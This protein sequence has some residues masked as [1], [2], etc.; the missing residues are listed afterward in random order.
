MLASR[1]AY[2]TALTTE[3]KSR[4]I[5]KHKKFN[6]SSLGIKLSKF[7]GYNSNLDIYTFQDKFEKLALK[8]TPID[9]LP[10]LLK[11]TYLEDPALSLVKNVTDIDDIWKRLKDAYGDCKIMLSKKMTEFGSIGDLFKQRDPSKTA[12]GLSKI[13][14]LMRDLIQLVKRHNIENNLYY[15]GAIDNVYHLMGNNRLDRWLTDKKA[16]DDGEVLWLELIEFLEKELGV[17]QLKAVIMAS[18]P[19]PPKSK[20]PPK[21]NPPAYHTGPSTPASNNIACSLCGE[22]DHVQTNGPGGMKLVQYFSCKKF[23]ESSCAQRL[24]SIFSR[25]FAF[26]VSSQVQMGAR[27]N[28]RKESVKEI[29]FVHILHTQATQ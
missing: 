7:K 22:T 3:E 29:L 6:Q 23:T 17:S 18:K 14:N 28:T 19:A 8:D 11:N 9:L 24:S 20:E 10:D 4:E 25:V 12:E 1:D 15:G 16:E 13:I 5:E 26:N 27:E 2:V 21:T